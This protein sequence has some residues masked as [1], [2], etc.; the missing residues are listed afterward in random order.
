MLL[1]QILKKA[2]WSSLIATQ[3][4]TSEYLIILA[5]FKSTAIR[6]HLAFGFGIHLPGAHLARLEGQI[7]VEQLVK[8]FKMSLSKAM[9]DAEGSGLGGPKAMMVDLQV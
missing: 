3:T 2:L 1:E 6:I 7:A 8:T 4:A 5:N 9:D